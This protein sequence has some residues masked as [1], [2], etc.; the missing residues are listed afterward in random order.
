MIYV[1]TK[2]Q[3]CFHVA[4]SDWKLNS[5]TSSYVEDN[6]PWDDILASL[7]DSGSD[8]PKQVSL[9][10]VVEISRNTKIFETLFYA[11]LICTATFLSFT[12]ILLLLQNL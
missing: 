8:D 9:Q 3:E 5:L 7:D 10:L 4:H 11:P 6:T 12:F 1:Y 2:F